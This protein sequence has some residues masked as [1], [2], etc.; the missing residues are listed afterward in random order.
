MFIFLH[1]H[2]IGRVNLLKSKCFTCGVER[3]C[4]AQTAQVQ[5]AKK[6]DEYVSNWGKMRLAV[7]R[8]GHG[9]LYAFILGLKELGVSNTVEELV[10][11]I[12]SEVM[13]NIDFYSPFV[14]DIDLVAELDNYL[15]SKVYN[16][17]LVDLML[18]VLA[19]ITKMSLLVF[20]T[21]MDGVRNLLVPPKQGRSRQMIHMAKLGQHYDAILN[22]STIKCEKQDESASKDYSRFQIT[23]HPKVRKFV[24]KFVSS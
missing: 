6:L 10:P 21:H 8:D 7:P 13:A 14:G 17:G 18:H 15:E 5:E 3:S 20:C 4:Y 24:A 11:K 12:K 1:R 22:V 2:S 19:N 23:F 9:I 16:S